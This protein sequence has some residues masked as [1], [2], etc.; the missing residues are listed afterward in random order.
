M[1]R[2]PT[3]DVDIIIRA[4]N[5]NAHVN[6]Y[7]VHTQINWVGPGS[8]YIGFDFVNGEKLEVYRPEKITE[9][10]TYF[11]IRKAT[12]INFAFSENGQQLTIVWIMLG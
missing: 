4:K 2:S 5:V 12:A 8:R 6:L 11:K 9:A 7:K 3:Y 1:K 10:R